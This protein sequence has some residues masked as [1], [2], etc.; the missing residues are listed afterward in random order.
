MGSCLVSNGVHLSNNTTVKVLVG[1]IYI[2]GVILQNDGEWG[3]R[4]RKK[5][6]QIEERTVDIPII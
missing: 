1:C 4:H 5:I 3:Y 6:N 2:W